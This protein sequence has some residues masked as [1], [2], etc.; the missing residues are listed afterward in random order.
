MALV[1]VLLVGAALLLAA[2][3][4]SPSSSSKSTTTT[5]AGTSKSTT[6]T[7]APIPIQN[8]VKIRTQAAI[9]SCR[10]ASDGWTA[11]GTATNPG[12]QSHT[13]KLI[14]YFTDTHA[15]VI[16]SAQTSVD[17]AAK[18]AGTWS[19]TGKFPAPSKVRCV[20][21]GVE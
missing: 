21:V 9:T 15:T 13:Y 6:T 20:L 8:N 2:C 3:S 17:V 7:T 1:S 12:S 18:A 10:Q 5:V 16:G 11:A 4:S 19:V 14:I